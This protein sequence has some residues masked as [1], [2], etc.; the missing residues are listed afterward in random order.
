M[1]D[2]YDFKKGERDKF[3]RP[4]AVLELPVYLDQKVHAS[5]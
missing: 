2:E 5:G 3:D 4:G 1:R